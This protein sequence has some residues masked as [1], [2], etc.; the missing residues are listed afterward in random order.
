[1]TFPTSCPRC[2]STDGFFTRERVTLVYAYMFGRSDS[3][4]RADT[5]HTDALPQTAKCGDCQCR[6]PFSH[7]DEEPSDWSDP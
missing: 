2:G 4:E 5:I 3:R 7:E 1:M 6:F